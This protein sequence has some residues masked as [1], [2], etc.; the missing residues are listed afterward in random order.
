MLLRNLSVIFRRNKMRGGA[1]GRVAENLH[2]KFSLQEKRGRGGGD[3]SEDNVFK[4][5]SCMECGN[6]S[7]KINLFV[8][9]V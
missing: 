7:S 1:G 3:G 5:M 9:H 6:K 4:N 2:Y 8:I